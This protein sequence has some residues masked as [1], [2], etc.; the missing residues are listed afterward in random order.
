MVDL[1]Q[2]QK[3]KRPSDIEKQTDIANAYSYLKETNFYVIRN[4]ET[5]AVIP[6]HVREARKKAYA[7]IDAE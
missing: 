3:I 1:S 4:L 2:L 6:E 5:G 7:T